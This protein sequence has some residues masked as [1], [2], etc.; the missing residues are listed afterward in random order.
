M[1]LRLQQAAAWGALVCFFLFWIGFW[2]L[3]GFVPPPSPKDSPEEIAQMFQEDKNRIRIGMIT[4]MFAVTFLGPLAAV[5]TLQMRRI[6][7]K[8]SI[9]AFTQLAMGAIFVLEFIYLIF[10]WQTATYRSDRSPETIQLLNDM[11]WIPFMGLTSTGM[12]QTIVFGVAILRDRRSD[13]VFP[14]WSGYFM[15]FVA[16][17]YTPGSFCVFFKDGPLAWNGIISFYLVMA[18]FTAWVLVVPVLLHR[19]INQQREEE[20]AA[21]PDRDMAALL[22]GTTWNVELLA[23]ELI[24]VKKELERVSARTGA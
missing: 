19:A 9:L 4:C 14:R 15:I 11:S 2:V 23:A 12:L 21:R 10:F 8:H 17:C 13:P 24:S 1:N 20:Q 5:I 3:A 18:A 6:E 16:T 7:G 22:N